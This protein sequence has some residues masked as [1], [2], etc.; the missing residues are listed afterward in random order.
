MPLPKDFIDPEPL[1][2]RRSWGRSFINPVGEALIRQLVGQGENQ[3]DAEVRVL[4][5]GALSLAL[6]QRPAKR[7]GIASLVTYLSDHL[8][9]LVEISLDARGICLNGDVYVHPVEWQRAAILTEDAVLGLMEGGE[10]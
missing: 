10:R 7:M 6:A 1:T 5:Q 2:A 4:G 9:E 8:P 3:L